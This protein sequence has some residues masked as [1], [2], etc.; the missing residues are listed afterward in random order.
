M[1][2]II[3][4]LTVWHVSQAYPYLSDIDIY[5]WAVKATQMGYSCAHATNGV[6]IVTNDPYTKRL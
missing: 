4:S 6:L 1:T 5:A 2:D 3:V